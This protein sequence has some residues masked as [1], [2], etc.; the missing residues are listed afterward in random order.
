MQFIPSTWAVVGV[1][2]DGDGLR[3]PQDI[4]DAALGTA[5]Y[6][7]SGTDDLG[8]DAGR[9][10]AVYRYNHSQP[11]VDL[12]L[13]IMHAYLA[14]DFTSIPNGTTAAGEHTRTP[15]RCDVPGTPP[16]ASAPRPPPRSTADSPPTDR[17]TGGRHVGPDR[18]Q[19]RP[20]DPSPPSRPPVADGRAAVAASTRRHRLDPPSTPC[21]RRS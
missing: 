13:A 17:P 8:T 5:V 3:N 2:A 15:P 6:L 19:H 20:T 10:A 11:Y 4:D 14:G 9:R 16:R 12:V 21:R 18:R 7:C 1:D